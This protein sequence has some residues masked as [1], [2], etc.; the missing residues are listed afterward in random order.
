MFQQTLQLAWFAV[1]M[2]AGQ[3]ALDFVVIQQL[4][5]MTGVFSRD[6]LDKEVASGSVILPPDIAL[7]HHLID[8]WYRGDRDSSIEGRPWPVTEEDDHE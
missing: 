2:E 4:R 6:Q 1:L 8:G 7:A 5:S 3:G